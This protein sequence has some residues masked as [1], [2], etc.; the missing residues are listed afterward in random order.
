G[1]ARTPVGKVP[2]RG[3]RSATPPAR[4][5]RR[6]QPGPNQEDRHQR[7]LERTVVVIGIEAEHRLDPVVPRK[8]EQRE[9]TVNRRQ[10]RL[11]PEANP[12]SLS[13]RTPS[14]LSLGHPT[15]SRP[16]P[17]HHTPAPPPP[18]RHSPPRL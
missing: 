10:D 1:G 3:G 13:H 8:R 7:P 2:P 14:G 15:D 11:A 12:R 6:A 5:K 18:R 9:Q 4:G 16:R 17:P